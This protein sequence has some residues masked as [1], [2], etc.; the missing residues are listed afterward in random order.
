MV[1]VLIENNDKNF[2]TE[3]TQREFII[4]LKDFFTN[5]GYKRGFADFDMEN[6]TLISFKPDVV[7]MAKA[8]EN[9]RTKWNIKEFETNEDGEEY[10]FN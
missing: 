4:L 6:N 5:K 7:N 10:I 8:E 1:K 3:S 2:M 9:F